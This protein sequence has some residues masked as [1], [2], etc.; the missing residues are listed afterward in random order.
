MKHSVLNELSHPMNVRI[1]LVTALGS[2]DE[3]RVCAHYEMI[4]IGS[5]H[6]RVTHVMNLVIFIHGILLQL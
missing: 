2:Y 3:N 5:R 6:D 1:I 4:Y